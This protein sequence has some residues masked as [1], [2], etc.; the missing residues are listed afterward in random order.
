MK[1]DLNGLTSS[2]L[3]ALKSTQRTPG[4]T[5]ATSPE[6]AVTEEAATVSIEGASVESL[7]TKAL[8]AS[9]IRQD[10]VES[11]RQAVQNGTYE[12]DP[13]QIA[14]AMIRQSE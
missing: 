3:D 4:E 5:A 1:V 9:E 8:S 11:L 12:I 7:V 6:N 2:T 13:A 10:K 14:E